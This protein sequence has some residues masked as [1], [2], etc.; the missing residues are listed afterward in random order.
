MLK[1]KFIS[2]FF[3]SELTAK[4]LFSIA[5]VF[6]SILYIIFYNEWLAGKVNLLGAPDTV[7]PFYSSFYMTNSISNL[8]LSSW[9]FYNQTDFAYSHMST[10]WWTTAG[11]GTA[12]TS[13][14]A[15]YF[16]K[17]NGQNFV[18][19]HLVILVACHLFL[20]TIGLILLMKKYQLNNNT[21]IITTCLV[22]PI[23]FSKFSLSYHV[24]IVYASI[25]LFI[26]L[27]DELRNNFS[28]SSILKFIVFAIAIVFQQPLF[29]IAYL[30]QI[31][32]FYVVLQLIIN[33]KNTIVSVKKLFQHLN[34]RLFKP[35]FSFSLV[36]TAHSIY[37]VTTIFLFYIFSKSIN[38][39]YFF[40]D[41][42][43]QSPFINFQTLKILVGTQWSEDFSKIL[44]T[45][46]T[47]M[48]S[49]WPFMGVTFVFFSI[50]GLL[51]R[52]NRKL[53]S[54]KILVII[55]IVMQFSINKSDL[56]DKWNIF[57]L[58][59]LILK[60]LGA[61]LRFF[62]YL[63]FPFSFLFRSGSMLVWLVASILIVFFAIG[64]DKFIGQFGQRLMA[65]TY[66]IQ[67]LIALA[68]LLFLN[69]SVYV[70]LTICV[71][72]LVNAFLY[73]KQKKNFISERMSRRAMIIVVSSFLL[74]DLIF[75]ATDA[76]VSEYSGTRLVPNSFVFEEYSSPYFTPQY[77][78]PFSR[79]S[80]NVLSSGV[81]PDVLPIS[82][83]LL[84]SVYKDG[85]YFGQ[86]E[87]N[88]YFYQTTYVGNYKFNSYYQNK[89]I[90]F[91]NYTGLS[92]S[93]YLPTAVQDSNA[94]R[95][96]LLFKVSINKIEVGTNFK[97]T[98]NIDG[99]YLYVFDCRCNALKLRSSFDPKV[100]TVYFEID[101]ERYY[102]VKGKPIS[103]KSFDFGNFYSG[104]LTFVSR[105]KPS[106][107]NS[108]NLQLFSVDNTFKGKN[109]FSESEIYAG[110]LKIDNSA[111]K[112]SSITFAI[113][114]QT[115]WKIHPVS[116]A[117]LHSSNGWL[118]I[119][120]LESRIYRLEFNPYFPLPYYLPFLLLLWT[121]V[122]LFRVPFNLLNSKRH[123]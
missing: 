24:S 32:F 107:L 41:N 26:Y 4:Q 30:G 80:F 115:G 55:F 108:A 16:F 96:D 60:I 111:Q 35:R 8:N 64:L 36:H 1:S 99:S 53:T 69:H 83:A 62:L 27:I 121:S 71:G 19:I 116:N 93:E 73:L 21:I 90:L 15:N 66:S 7:I 78:S 11:L 97:V 49:G 29:A 46:S 86:N 44:T 39:N 88:S 102:P 70:L 106:Y 81:S 91:E 98:K 28:L 63:T 110:G 57:D 2:K 77:V 118:K 20:R 120:N 76:E 122:I 25:F 103:E 65:K 23:I 84:L 10:G 75:S 100:N 12:I 101:G 31:I 59:I 87:L 45:S 67:I 82:K 38:T 48:V 51:N 47:G 109:A 95:D 22:S 105:I 3:T 112:A 13:I 89:N 104:K 6:N 40:M 68:L 17:I 5:F 119:E 50:L 113:P 43:A 33:I 79:L 37:I 123:K 61:L 94:N 34:S 92:K 117:T 54:L 72:I 114:F 14:I 56:N 58:P 42:R 18:Q 74:F 85:N 52:N 9:N